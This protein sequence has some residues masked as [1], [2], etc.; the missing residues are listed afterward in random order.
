MKY[1]IAGKYCPLCGGTGIDLANGLRVC[2]GILLSWVWESE[3]EYNAM[4]ESDAYHVAEQL[5]ENQAPFK[6][7]DDDY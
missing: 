1:N 5:R 7:R 4:Y 3:A 2:C 6:D